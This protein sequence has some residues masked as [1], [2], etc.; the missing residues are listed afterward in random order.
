[1]R[2]WYTQ[3]KPWFWIQI[4]KIAG[5]MIKN[6][7]W[8]RGFKWGLKSQLEFYVGPMTNLSS[9]VF[10]SK[11][12]SNPYSIFLWVLVFTVAGPTKFISPVFSLSPPL[13]LCLSLSPLGYYRAQTPLPSSPIIKPHI[14]ITHFPKQTKNY[15]ITS[16]QINE[17]SKM[18]SQILF[19]FP[20]YFLKKTSSFFIRI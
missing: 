20:K 4:Q 11:P 6:L 7:V 16:I 14:L 5:P 9:P 2:V 3:L 13:L 1:M 15:N 10:E 18:I 8:Y 12:D 17:P 19:L